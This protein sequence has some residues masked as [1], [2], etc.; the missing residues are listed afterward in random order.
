M[1]ISHDISALSID[2]LLYLG[3]YAAPRVSMAVPDT[4]HLYIIIF[5]DIIAVKKF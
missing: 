4:N 5:V 1:Q 3:K 2:A